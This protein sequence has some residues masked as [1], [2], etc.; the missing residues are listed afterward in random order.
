[1]VVP[2]SMRASRQPGATHLAARGLSAA[3]VDLLAEKRDGPLVDRS[4]VPFLDRRK[5]GFSGLVARP[6]APAMGLEEVRRRGQ[7]AGRG[8]EA[9]AA[10]VVQDGLWQELGLADL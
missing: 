9:S 2:H 6:R 8:I 4:G 7:R 5:I 10:G 1:M 3:S